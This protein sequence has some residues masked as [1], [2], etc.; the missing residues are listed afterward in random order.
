MLNERDR[1]NWARRDVASALG[2]L[3][4]AAEFTDRIIGNG[5]AHVERL[6]AV[7][8][9][10]WTMADVARDVERELAEIHAAERQTTH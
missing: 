3:T 5:S 7:R 1:I 6:T 2:N 9:Q 4:G 8:Q 10:L